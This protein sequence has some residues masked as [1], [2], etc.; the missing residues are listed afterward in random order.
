MSKQNSSPSSQD[1]RLNITV[2][3][4]KTHLST[5]ISEG[6]DLIKMIQAEP[7]DNKF[8]HLFREWNDYNFEF[9]KQCFHNRLN[10]QMHS[11][12]QAGNGIIGALGEVRGNPT[13]SLLNSIEYKMT[14]LTSLLKRANLFKSTVVE[15]E[16]PQPIP[17]NQ[18]ATNEVFIVHGHDELA[19][20]SVAR[21]LEKL[22]L[23]PIILHEQTSSGRT[24][25]EKIEAYTNVR[26]GVVLYTECD[27]G[28]KDK[29]NLR[30]RA[31]QNVVFEHG[32][33]I[34]KI[35]RE[36]V[37]ALVKGSIET[38]GDISGVVYTAMDDQ[39]AWHLKLAKELRA[40]G[41]NIDLNKL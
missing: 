7:F 29:D 11:Y 30:H 3:D 39:E 1:N 36:K 18:T 41:Y 37:C 25:I 32:Y 34:G 23:K 17:I 13:Q 4:F 10:D 33:L 38:P 12:N 9:L 28:G 24:I 26:F 27:L 16:S 35:G 19:K 22:N 6:N 15:E 31:R 2:E 14:N 40:A 21:F 20:V 5:Q 8:H